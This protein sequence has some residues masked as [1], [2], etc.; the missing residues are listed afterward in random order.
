MKYHFQSAIKASMIFSPEEHYS[1]FVFWFPK[2]WR[3][4]SED[5]TVRWRDEDITVS[6][7]SLYYTWRNDLRLHNRMIWA[8]IIAMFIYSGIVVIWDSWILICHP[9][10][11]FVPS[12]SRRA[13]MTLPGGKSKSADLKWQQ[14]PQ[15][16]H[17]CYNF[18]FLVIDWYVWIF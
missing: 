4:Y 17:Y 9:A 12:G 11:S 5:I 15:N 18:I 6:S 10:V 13:Q 3:H 1:V 16:E 2:I 8:I 7:F 14:C